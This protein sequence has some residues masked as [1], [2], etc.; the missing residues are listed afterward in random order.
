MN[1]KS[2]LLTL[3]MAAT[4][5]S[6]PNIVDV[7]SRF[8]GTRTV[9]VQTPTFYDENEKKTYPL[10][11]LL[12]GEYL[13]D[14]FRGTMSYTSFWDDLPQVIIVGVEHD[15]A[16]GRQDDVITYKSTGLPQGQGDQ[17]YQFIADELIPFM[18]KEYRVAPFKVVAGH[19]ITAG[20]LNFFL[21]KEKPTFNAYISFSPVMP[22]Q[23]EVR[24]PEVLNNI[25][26]KT[27]YY[28][29]TADNDVKNIKKKVDTLNVNIKG[30]ENPNLNYKFEEFKG[31]THYSLVAMGIPDALYFIFADYQP[32]TSKEYEEEIVTLPSGY[33]EYLKNKYKIIREDLGINI[34]IRLNDFKAIE[35]AIV[36][37]G[38]Y[39]ELEELGKMA[40]DD[41]PKMIIGEYYI[42]LSHELKGETRKAIRAYLK[43]YNYGDIGDYTKDLIIEKAEQLKK[44]TE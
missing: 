24:V 26:K 1:Y 44:L 42:G 37:N 6:Q 17:F 13:M 21:Y 12:D 25:D 32:I 20:F 19:N 7:P 16:E 15:G 41:Y 38:V 5:Y 39:D 9:T 3:L 43:G 40:R 2:L 28:L 27:Y 23:M 14:P 36:K 11:I 10:I 22:E 34:P 31:A 35:A 29:A 33:V 8:F 30:I 4:M 18:E